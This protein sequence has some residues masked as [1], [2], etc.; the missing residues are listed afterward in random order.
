MDL[1]DA[2][3]FPVKELVRETEKAWQI[4]LDDGEVHWFPKSKCRLVD[5][6]LFVPEW[7]VK[8][9]NIEVG[10]MSKKEKPHYHQSTLTNYYDCPRKMV[11]AQEHSIEQTMPMREGLLFEYF[12]LG[13]N[14]RAIKYYGTP[15]KYEE[16]LIGRKKAETV[17]PIRKQADFIRPHF[18]E[19]ENA[20]Q[21]ISYE[22]KEYFNS[23]EADYIGMLE[24]LGKTEQCIADL[25]YV[26]DVASW[27]FMNK[28]SDYFQSLY[29]TYIVWK[30]TGQ[31]L[32]FV[33]VVV[34]KKFEVPLVAFKRVTFTI[35]NFK[36][37]KNDIDFIHN[38]IIKKPKVSQDTCIKGSYNKQCDYVQHCQAGRELLESSINIEFD[39]LIPNF[40]NPLDK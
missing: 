20:F 26:G 9:K 34:D 23:G 22:D 2:K 13:M 11:L 18:L 27:R 36:Q 12:A 15:Q 14:P 35:D 28:A 3:E 38:D 6:V 33:Y 39:E 16:S 5:K 25:K 21:T 1:T 40:I 31:N 32:P 17:D 37:L 10:K 19:L 30:T 8:S 24:Y 7:M 4:K 29:Y